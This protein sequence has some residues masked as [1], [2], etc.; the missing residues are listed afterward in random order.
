MEVLR[1]RSIEAPASR[2]KRREPARQ[3]R[4]FLAVAYG[5]IALYVS[6]LR[7]RVSPTFHRYPTLL[8]DEVRISLQAASLC[9]CSGDLPKRDVRRCS[10]WLPRLSTALVKAQKHTR[11]NGATKDEYHAGIDCLHVL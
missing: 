8:T 2:E 5:H 9:T 4:G 6:A 7:R 11:G 10:I 3:K 1:Q